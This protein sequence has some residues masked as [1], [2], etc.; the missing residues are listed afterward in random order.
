MDD[1]NITAYIASNENDVARGST[2]VHKPAIDWAIP[3]I[4]MVFMP[5]KPLI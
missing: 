5:W 2:S 4:N 1:P 3:L